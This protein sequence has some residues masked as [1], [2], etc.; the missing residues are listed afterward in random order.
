MNID[1]TLVNAPV[2]AD[3]ESDLPEPRVPETKTHAE[4][5]HELFEGGLGI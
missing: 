5:D 3:R 4:C 1:L 2:M